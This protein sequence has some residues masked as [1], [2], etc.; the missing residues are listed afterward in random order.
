MADELETKTV[1]QS[2]ENTPT[3]GSGQP[4]A[5]PDKLFR[6]G[7][8]KERKRYEERVTAEL[9]KYNV[10]PIKD[11]RGHID[12]PASLAA[13]VRAG[14]PEAARVLEERYAGRI[15][16]LSQENEGLKSQLSTVRVTTSVREKISQHNPVN[17]DDATDLF[18]MRYNIR[19]EDGEFVVCDKAG[20]MLHHKVTLSPLT[21]EDAVEEFFASRPGLREQRKGTGLEGLGS[22]KGAP[23][24]SNTNEDLTTAYENALA[25]G[26]KGKAEQIKREM[27]KRIKQAAEM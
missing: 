20:N 17:L 11:A 7:I 24:R 4:P 23:G 16:E 18:M 12:I 6:S 9:G 5:D 26:D 8:N 10:E 25:E 13:L 2:E 19:Q 22:L 21:I 1:E 15:A 3:Q 27:K 14:Q